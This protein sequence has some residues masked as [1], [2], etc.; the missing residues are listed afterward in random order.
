MFLI[1]WN[2]RDGSGW[3]GASSAAPVALHAAEV[4]YGCRRRDRKHRMAGTTEKRF[5]RFTLLIQFA[6]RIDSIDPPGAKVGP[7]FVD[8]IARVTPDCVLDASIEIMIG[9]ENQIVRSPG[10]GR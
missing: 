6:P 5:C 4:F 7:G 8:W 10:F 9:T 3:L 2:A 1:W